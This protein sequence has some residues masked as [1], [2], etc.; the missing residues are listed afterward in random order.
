[1]GKQSKYRTS[2]GFVA[3][4]GMVI[5]EQY[6]LIEPIGSGASCDVWSAYHL[7]GDFI[8][9]L[10]FLNP[11]RIAL[12]LGKDEFKLLAQIYHPNII[13]TFDMSYVI[14]KA[15]QPFMSMEFMNGKSFKHVIDEKIEVD[16]KHVLG[17]MDQLI[18][19]L[20][21]LRRIN[22]I[23]KDIK[24][25][26]I[27]FEGDKAVLIDFNISLKN[28]P[29]VGTPAYKCPT[30]NQLGIWTFYADLWALTLSFYEILTRREVFEFST[31][32][33]I[34]LDDICPPGFPEKTFNALKGIIQGAGKNVEIN[35]IKELFKLEK[36]ES[37]WKITPKPV[38]EKYS[39]SSRNQ[40]FI[41]LHLMNQSSYTTPRSKK[42]ILS[43]ALKQSGL[44]AGTDAMKKLRPVLSQLKKKMVIEYTGKGNQKVVLSQIF[45]EDLKC[46]EN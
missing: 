21:Y 43:E 9:A 42:V 30:V 34:E 15:Q 22:I 35:Q 4:P 6:K 29:L 27:M 10:K 14:G 7:F 44:P 38:C 40:K 46:N 16:P 19:A 12:N 1:M 18:S 39:I 26:N 3:E 17:W 11:T 45:I 37:K 32:F 5:N 23:H 20:R 8:C 2:Y 41:T 13:R 31:S 25:A 28:S 33:D 24:P 36:S